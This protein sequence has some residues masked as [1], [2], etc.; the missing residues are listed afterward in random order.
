MTKRLAALIIILNLHVSVFNLVAKADNMQKVSL[1]NG[2]MEMNVINYGARIQTLKFAGTDVVLGF[3]TLETYAKKKQNFGAIVGRYIG[4]IIGGKLPLAYLDKTNKS[5]DTLQL[6]VG[7][8]GD[9]SDR[10]SV[11]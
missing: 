11:V 1:S 3:D 8:N 10:K 9:C 2:N 7:G 5:G 6:Q 4:R